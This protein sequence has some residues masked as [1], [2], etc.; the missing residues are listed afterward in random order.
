M[1]DLLI[2][3]YEHDS[4]VL[5]ADIYNKE[6]MDG[7]KLLSNYNWKTGEVN[8]GYYIGLDWLKKGEKALYVEPKL[9]KTSTSTDY[10]KMLFECLKHPEVYDYTKDLFDIQFEE[11]YIEIEQTKDLLTPLL[12]IQFLQVL[13]SIVKKGL[14][15]SYYKR[16]ENL[17]GRIKGKVLVGKTIKQNILQNKSLKTICSFDEFGLDCKENR[18]LKKT[19]VFV[20]R[21]LKSYPTVSSLGNPIMIFCLP[22]FETV[23]DRIEL[24]EIK[25]VVSNPF[26]KEYKEA[27]RLA[28]LILKRFAYNINSINTSEKVE[29]PPFW[30][31][32]SKLFE[33]YV[34]GL[35][36]DRFGNEIEFQAQGNYGQPDYLLCSHRMIIDAKYKTYY[37]ENF[38]GQVQWQRDAIAKDIRQLSGYSRD[39]KVLEK[40]GVLKEDFKSTIPSCLFIYPHEDGVDN[41]LTIDQK[42]FEI[43]PFVGFYKIGVKLPPLPIQNK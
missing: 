3:K 14:K 41:L 36:K 6:Q 17:T 2:S 10:L 42:M 39:K 38:K 37:K 27:I 16:E 5:D 7:L 35:L 30:I 26:Y 8:L 4:F 12:V 43:E 21:Y 33:L 13:H 9:N 25:T 20:Q 18:L 15:K 31:D 29:V 11:T 34:L 22:A 28:K 1:C 32:M 40:L 23:S 19:L 24:N